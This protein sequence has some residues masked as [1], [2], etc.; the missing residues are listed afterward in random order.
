MPDISER[1]NHQQSGSAVLTDVN[2]TSWS[3]WD[4]SYFND[5]AFTE[6]LM[7]CWKISSLQQSI[8][9]HGQRADMHCTLTRPKLKP[10]KAMDQIDY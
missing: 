3:S 10:E 2:P 6:C 5:V 8:R 4:E 1:L 9:G 7:S